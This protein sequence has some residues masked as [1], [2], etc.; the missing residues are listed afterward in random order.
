[1]KTAD[2][3]GFIYCHGQSAAV[4]RAG[5]VFVQGAAPEH[6]AALRKAMHALEMQGEIVMVRRREDI[7]PLDCL[8]VPG[9][10]S[11]TISKLITRFGIREKI[12]GMAS[13]GKPI[14][15]TCAGCVLLAKEGDAQVDRTGTELL[16]LMDMSV[17]RNAF[18]RQVDSFE[19]EVAVEGIAPDFHAVFIRAPLI[20]RVWGGCVPMSTYDGKITMARHGNVIASAFHPELS[21]DTRVH[22][23][24]LRMA[25]P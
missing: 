20:T 6:V 17:D 8:I 7:T 11:T 13:E 24:F 3:E 18:G 2:H 4:I 5:V 25:E 22:Q 15:G 19:A 16:G 21:R 9:G 10:E 1:M 23:M 14:L 12:I